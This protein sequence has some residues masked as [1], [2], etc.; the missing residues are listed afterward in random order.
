MADGNLTL[1]EIRDFDTIKR[2]V[3]G[4]VL[5][6]DRFDL[7][8]EALTANEVEYSCHYYNKNHFGQCD[9]NHYLDV[10]CAQIIESYILEYEL[11]I[12]GLSFPI[13]TW[14]AKLEIDKSN[15]GDVVWQSILDGDLAGFSPHGPCY[16]HEVTNDD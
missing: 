4:P 12:N 7:H 5:I 1:P 8:N 14:M 11:V 16:E 6:P 2:H 9:L 3:L 15:T 10:D 13:G